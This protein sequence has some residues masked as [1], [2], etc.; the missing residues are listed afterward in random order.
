MGVG[1]L[2]KKS[3]NKC[4]Y[5]THIEFFK[6]ISKTGQ[7]KSRQLIVMVIATSTFHG[8]DCTHTSAMY[9]NAGV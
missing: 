7:R 2:E 3:Y 1:G 6:Q 4:V 5:I 8:H 9:S